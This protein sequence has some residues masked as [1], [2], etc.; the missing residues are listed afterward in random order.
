MFLLSLFIALR[1]LD[2]NKQGDM[3]CKVA[4][5]LYFCLHTQT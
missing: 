4:G 3:P 5:M 1:E 2:E